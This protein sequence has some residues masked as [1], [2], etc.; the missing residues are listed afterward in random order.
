ML[1]AAGAAPTPVSITHRG[2][3]ARHETGTWSVPK[4]VLMERMATAMDQ[5]RLK[6]ICD[7]TMGRVFAGEARNFVRTVNK[8]GHGTYVGRR[9]SHDDLILAVALAMWAR[10]ESSYARG[11]FAA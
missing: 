3:T 6:I 7:E 1:R 10:A 5:G 8:L 11:L 2:R 9:R 4:A